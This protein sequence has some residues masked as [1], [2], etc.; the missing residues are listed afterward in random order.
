M[1]IV[2]VGGGTAGWM[3]SLFMLRWAKNQ[4]EKVEVTVI[5]SS[6]I[7][8]IGAGEGSTGLF[9]DFI[10]TLLSEFGETHLSFIYKTGATLKLGIRFK[11]WNGVGTEYLSPIEPSVS[12]RSNI[13]MMM[14]NGSL[15][16]KPHYSCYTGYLLEKGLST[17]YHNKQT[18]TGGN[19][20]HFD[21]HK[22]GQYFKEIAVKHSATHID[23]EIK[24]L[25]R[26]P[27]NGNLES[28]ILEDGKVLEGDL[29]IDCSGFGRVLMGPMGGGWESYSQYLPVNG[30]IPYL[31]PH[32]EDV[33]PETV[34][35]AQKNGWMWQIPTQQRYGCGYVYS[36]MFTTYDKAVEEL[37]QTTNRKIEPLRNLKFD[38]GRLKNFWVNN[39]TSVGLS[40]GFLEP[41]QATSIHTTIVQLNVITEHLLR[42]DLNILNDGSVQKSYNHRMGRMFDDFRDLIQIHYMTKRDDSDFWKYVKNGLP[43]LDK[44]KEILKICEYRSPSVLDWDHYFGSAGWGVLGWTIMGLGLVDK[45]FIKRDLETTKSEM[46]NKLSIE[47]ENMMVSHKANEIKLMRNS[48]FLKHIK[49][50]KIIEP[51][52]KI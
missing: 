41:L 47:W 12:S 16:D 18:A 10:S 6:K 19:S 44:T 17:Y 48:E 32:D 22:V 31:Y 34:A 9:S 39:V 1:K 49:E 13:D 43:K 46:R 42:T 40:S 25:K 3:S 45:E 24:N 27:I 14:L 7:P 38:V 2:I 20:Y 26:N 11:D 33:R 50:N 23:S 28:V 35:W 37:E 8:I 4:K 30:A 21:A 29:W 5:D 52:N 51:L 15:I 36:D